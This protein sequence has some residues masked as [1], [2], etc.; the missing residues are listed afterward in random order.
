MKSMFGFT[1]LVLLAFA[2][3][4][5]PAAAQYLGTYRQ[6]GGQGYGTVSGPNG[7]VVNYNHTKI[8][9]FQNTTYRDSLGQVVHCNTSTT[10]GVVNTYCY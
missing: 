8:G 3:S 9:S 5:S 4:A 10:A 2:A 7:Y 6:I 1:A